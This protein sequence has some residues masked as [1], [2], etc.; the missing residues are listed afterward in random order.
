M[1]ELVHEAGTHVMFENQEIVA[2]NALVNPAL[3]S[4]VTASWVMNYMQQLISGASTVSSEQDADKVKHL[5]LIFEY[6]NIYLLNILNNIHVTV[7]AYYHGWV[8]SKLSPWKESMDEHI[9]LV[10]QV[11]VIFNIISLLIAIHRASSTP[12]SG[13]LMKPKQKLFA[14]MDK[15]AGKSPRDN[16]EVMTVIIVTMMMTIISRLWISASS[17]CPTCCW[18]VAWAALCSPSSGS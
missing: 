14:S 3:R 7:R 6:L 10:S 17:S 16:L 11:G 12:Q 5:N 13:I 9:L 4:K 8:F 15:A 1:L 2:H 18:W